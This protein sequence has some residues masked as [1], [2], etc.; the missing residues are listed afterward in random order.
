MNPNIKYALGM[1]IETLRKATS[2]D[3]PELA[4]LWS[5]MVQ[6]SDAQDISVSEWTRKA[7]TW[8]AERIILHSDEFDAHVI[9]G[10]TGEPLVACGMAWVDERIPTSFNPSGKRVHIT[11]LYTEP[12]YRGLGYATAI[13]RALLNWTRME[14]GLE[15][16]LTTTAENAGLY[17]RGGFKKTNY[18]LMRSK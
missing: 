2:E 7:E 8:I 9:G 11:G 5:L 18:L 12:A 4:R 6:S 14:C 1:G 10:K 16:E 13:I 17:E 3:A 15:A